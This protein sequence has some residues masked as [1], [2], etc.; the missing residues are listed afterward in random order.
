MSYFRHKKNNA[1]LVCFEGLATLAASFLSKS[2]PFAHAQT[3]T[4]PHVRITTGTPLNVPSRFDGDDK[5]TAYDDDA[6]VEISVN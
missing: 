4:R 5:A 1:V 2:E 6:Q 3:R